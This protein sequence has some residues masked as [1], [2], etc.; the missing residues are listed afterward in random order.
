MTVAGMGRGWRLRGRGGDG[1]NVENG[2]GMGM[3]M[4]GAVFIPVQLSSDRATVTDFLGVKN[5]YHCGVV[6]ETLFCKLPTSQRGVS[7]TL[8]YYFFIFDIAYFQNHQT[9]LHQM[10][11]QDDKYAAMKS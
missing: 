4:T 7:L 10:F 11:Q 9:D 1:D 5:A 3:G 6:Y 2:D 8:Y